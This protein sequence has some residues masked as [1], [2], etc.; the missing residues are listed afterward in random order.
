MKNAYRVILIVL[1]VL[2][3]VYAS[4]GPEKK[5]EEEKGETTEKCL[6]SGTEPEKNT[7]EAQYKPIDLCKFPLSMEVGHYIQLKE[8]RKRKIT[9]VQVDCESIGKGSG[10]FP[11]YKGSD[12]IEVR[13]NFP[14]IF[15]ASI[16]KN[17]G[18]EDMLKEV[19]LYWENGVNTIQGNGDWE[20][21]TLCLE[22]WNVE[23]WKSGGTIGTVGIGEITIDVRPP[24]ITLCDKAPMPRSSISVRPDVASAD[25]VGIWTGQTADKPDE[26]STTD[27][28]ILHVREPSES[29]WKASISGTFPSD[30][31]QEVGQIQLVDNKIGFYMQAMDGKTVVWLGLHPS[32]DDRL[33]GES[34]A[35]DPDCDGRD[36]ELVRKKEK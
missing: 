35:L 13:A 20:E 2:G 7:E 5:A 18:G 27:T 6:K 11:C 14:A 26:G 31:K 10:D 4:A 36:I 17:D 8:C 24:D 1:V 3:V 33:I 34:F 21:L 29:D 9:L 23:I 25:F 12:V 32:E 19:N 22:A 15:S 28:M 16:E 30:G